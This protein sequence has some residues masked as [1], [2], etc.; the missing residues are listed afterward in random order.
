MA[1]KTLL[2]FLF[3]SFSIQTIETLFLLCGGDTKHSVL[4]KGG[5]GQQ[6]S[7]LSSVQIK[8]GPSSLAETT[9]G[10]T[11]HPT[12]F[13]PSSV[14][15]RRS[16]CARAKKIPLRL[17]LS[18]VCID[19]AC[20]SVSLFLLV[21]LYLALSSFFDKQMMPKQFVVA[22][23]R[24]DDEQLGGVVIL[25]FRFFFASFLPADSHNNHFRFKKRRV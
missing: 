22:G 16:S 10:Q 4:P 1:P 24:D 20:P 14:Y 8:A 23:V 19:T 17:S 13:S 6:L 5:R 18:S 3:S 15:H 11:H 9:R 25:D 12:S 21:I 2:S 7:C